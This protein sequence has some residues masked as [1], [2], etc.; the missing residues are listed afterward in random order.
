MTIAIRHATEDDFPELRL[1]VKFLDDEL[2][3]QGARSCADAVIGGISYALRSDQ[4]IVVA[5]ATPGGVVGFVAWA[6]VPGVPDGS[7]LGFGTYVRPAWRQAGVSEAMRDEAA[8]YYAGRGRQRVEGSV[9]RGNRSG[10]RSALAA[11]FRVTGYIVEKELDHEEVERREEV[12]REERRQGL[13]P[14]ELL[15]H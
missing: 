13:R 6:W 9:A 7:V 8:R 5:D 2:K 11:G 15:S 4:A 14:E 10:L 3:V 12:G 1:L